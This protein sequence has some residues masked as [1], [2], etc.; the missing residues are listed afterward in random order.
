VPTP[1]ETLA[2]FSAGYAPPP[3][4][5]DP[6][7]AALDTLRNVGAIPAEGVPAPA[8]MTQEQ[9]LANQVAAG[10]DA[11]SGADPRA[12][13][14]PAPIDPY[15]GGAPGSAPPPA[16]PA[17]DPYAMPAAPTTV[18]ASDAQLND[19]VSNAG[20]TAQAA[21]EKQL[22]ADTARAQRQAD[23]A[24]HSAD[25]TLVIQNDTRR[26]RDLANAQADA[27]TAAWLDQLTAQAK[28]EPNPTR[29][30][31]NLGGFGAAMWAISLLAG[32]GYAA[33]TPGAGN[34]AMVMLDKEI[35]KD[36][37]LQQQRLE[38][39]LTAL[40]QRGLTMKERQARK[41]TDLA[42][43]HTMRLTRIQALE[44]AWMA[45][46]TVPGDL[47]AQAA[48]AN[49]AA[50][51]QQVKLP[52]IEKR[53]T[54]LRAEKNAAIDRQ[55]DM[56][57][58]GARLA[59]AKAMQDDA[60]AHDE[61]TAAT[62]FGYDLALSPVSAG[63]TGP[64]NYNPVGKD[65]VPVYA[66]LQS[67]TGADGAPQVSLVGPNE[68][69]VRDGTVRFARDGKSFEKANVTIKTADELYDHLV[70]IRSKLSDVGPGA[71]LTGVRA[72]ELNAELQAA[73]YAVAQL[74]NDRVTDKDFSSAVAQIVGFDPN[75]GWLSRAKFA[76]DRD[77]VLKNLDHLIETHHKKVEAGLQQF[78]DAAIN[79][80]GTKIL[81]RPADLKP[82]A[83]P[84]EET[85]A[86]VRGDGPLR[87]A[88]LPGASPTRRAAPVTSPAD[89]EKRLAAGKADA[90]QT[91]LPAHD[92]GVVR[93]FL[94]QA[95]KRGPETVRAAA[96]KALADVDTK[97]AKLTAEMDADTRLATDPW[98]GIPTDE[99]NAKF[100]AKSAELT[101]LLETKAILKPVTV[102]AEKKAAETLAKFE[103]HVKF[104]RGTSWG[105]KVSPE[106]VKQRAVE[107]GIGGDA[108]AV[109]A[110]INKVN[111]IK[112]GSP[113]E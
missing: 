57:M 26:A 98:S 89:Y 87:S 68:K 107:M 8:P 51:F 82:D 49:A 3:N 88:S 72:A 64:G 62:K 80:Q 104:L 56:R 18:A 10:P 1:E 19:E 59:H 74:E 97:I 53:N 105:A 86:D 5:P 27:E 43:D 76:N 108:A 66:E 13:H 70:S 16:P 102:A 63:A 37:A 110:V 54:Q 29:Y 92:E 58:Q 69:P 44:R 11:V 61:K 36:V 65:G 34:A 84:A 42:D 2:A 7:A 85:S 4:L 22:A 15:Q 103:A 94:D 31:D 46:D 12:M 14:A 79:G 55:H 45:R 95:S 28:K 9:V 35:D 21:A 83:R 99:Q 40:K 39:E 20:R 100:D 47:D 67:R 112:S 75:G 109:D 52:Y 71:A 101:K 6:M 25:A 90:E 32:A 30:W 106:A 23:T 111:N 60:Q 91:T 33:L 96:A 50:L 78:N 113:F 24:Q 81:Y 73:G 77:G 38:R 48:K 17:P 41:A 93:K